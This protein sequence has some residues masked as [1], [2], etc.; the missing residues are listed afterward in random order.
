MAD[1]AAADDARNCRVY[2]NVSQ[3]LREDTKKLMAAGVTETEK[4]FY[5]GL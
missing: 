5:K 1:F 2:P 4:W 3:N